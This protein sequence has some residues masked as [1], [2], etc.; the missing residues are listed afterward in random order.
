MK[1]KGDIMKIR[2]NVKAGAIDINHNEKM[3][4]NKKVNSLTVKTGIKAGDLKDNIDQ[5]FIRR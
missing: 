2:T 4:S 5:P 3:A 1:E